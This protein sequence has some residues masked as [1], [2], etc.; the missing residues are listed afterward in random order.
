MQRVAEYLSNGPMIN[1]IKEANHE[2]RFQILAKAPNRK[3]NKELW[4]PLMLV[5]KSSTLLSAY[6]LLS[7]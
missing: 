3:T 2:Y 4:L 5:V 6:F 1:H 7:A